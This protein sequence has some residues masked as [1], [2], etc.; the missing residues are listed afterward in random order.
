MFKKILDY[1]SIKKRKY[2]YK[3]NSYSSC[4]LATWRPCVYQ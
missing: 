3:K 4:E 1:L 2:L